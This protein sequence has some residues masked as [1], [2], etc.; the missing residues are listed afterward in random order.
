MQVLQKGNGSFTLWTRYGRV[1]FDGVGSNE[2]AGDKASA[3]RMYNKK[4]REKTN[5]GYTEINMA[6]GKPD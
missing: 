6:L 2:A 4:Y 1:G 3:M 5:K